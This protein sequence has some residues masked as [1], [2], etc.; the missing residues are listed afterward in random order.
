MKCRFIRGNVLVTN[1][2]LSYFS[3]SIIFLFLE[4]FNLLIIVLRTLTFLFSLLIF[5]KNIS[6]IQYLNI[7]IKVSFC[8]FVQIFYLL[9]V[10]PSFP[11][12][13]IYDFL[14]FLFAPSFLFYI[15]CCCCLSCNHIVSIGHGLLKKFWSLVIGCVLRTAG[16]SII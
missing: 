2:R 1:C 8:I 4:F 14:S 15:S 9:C 5:T 10:F 7:F 11:F 16:S 3:S 12:L 13:P 6:L